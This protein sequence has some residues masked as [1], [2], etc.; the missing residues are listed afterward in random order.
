MSRLLLL[1]LFSVLALVCRFG[2]AAESPPRPD[3]V[4]LLADDL[5]YADVGFNGGR[6]VPTPHIDA[7]SK[8]G[9]VLEQ[10][11]VQ[12][13]CSPTR[14]AFMTGRYP[15]R[16]GLQEGVIRPHMQYGLPLAERTLAH[17]LRESGYTTAITGKWHL[18]EYHPS[19]LP[20]QRGFDF[21]YGHFF[22]ML[23]YNTH[24]RDGQRDWY[25]N[26]KPCDD[27]GYTTELIA[28]EAV[29]IVAEQ[30]REKPLFLYVPFNAVHSPYHTAPGREQDFEN[31]P[32]ARRE[33][34]TM[35]SEMDLAI[36]RILTA[37]EQA[38]RQQNA[39]IVFSS[40]NGGIG[41]ADNG[42]L[43]G[44]KGTPY[45]GGHRVAACVAWP[46]HIPAGQR[47]AQPL[48]IVDLL[49]TFAALAGVPLD[50]EHQPR[51]LDGLN[52]LPVLTSG[53]ATPHQEILLACEPNVAAI[54]VGDWK[55]VV[56]NKRGGKGKTPRNAGPELFNLRED[57]GEQSNLATQLPDKLHELQ[58]RLAKYQSEAVAPHSD[59]TGIV[60][61]RP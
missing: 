26:D 22:G 21:Q 49:P 45:E 46:G 48:H 8:R 41:P 61:S 1:V 7:L 5:G 39:F 51:S 9:A 57:P 38:G 14:A 54:R 27:V 31:L 13:V 40:D 11:Y 24:M 28:R 17:A 34:A 29:Q 42:P 43:R 18:G 6:D 32:Q 60:E 23:N 35:L 36:G 58:Q 19:F 55:L 4:I 20:L 53:A 2:G 12:T 16:Y 37:L 10:F 52:C 33:Y 50:A 3:F 56:N 15:M 44:N 25:R 59:P 30:P 47:I